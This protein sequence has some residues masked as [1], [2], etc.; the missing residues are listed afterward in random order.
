M[1]EQHCSNAYNYMSEWPNWAQNIVYDDFPNA[2]S[3]KIR[4][5][6]YQNSNTYFSLVFWGFILELLITLAISAMT[7]HNIWKYCYKQRRY[8]SVFISL[9]YILVSLMMVD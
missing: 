8:K 1:T 6:S 2:N 5:P 4:I 7:C 3:S 9:F